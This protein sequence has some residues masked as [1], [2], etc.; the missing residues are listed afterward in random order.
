M[1]SSQWSTAQWRE[2]YLTDQELYRLFIIKMMLTKLLSWYALENEKKKNNKP[3]SEQTTV[4]S[5]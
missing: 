1:Y 3:M 4:I 2:Q 5:L